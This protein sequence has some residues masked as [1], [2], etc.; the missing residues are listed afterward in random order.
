MADQPQTA[1]TGS[2]TTPHFSIEKL[3]LKDVSFESP[4]SPETFTIEGN[5]DISLQLNTETQTVGDDFYEVVLVV[6]AMAKV[7][8]KTAF[9]VELKQAGIFAVR[10]IPEADMA[11][12]LGIECPNILFSYAREAI[13][14]LTTKGG[15]QPLVLQPINF[16]AMFA[17][18]QAK[19][20]GE[21]EGVTLN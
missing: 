4:N 2:D 11:P 3:Y 17:E 6:T 16:A 10:N 7:N 9:L 15:F 5:P 8:D 1:D 19:K 18:A 12:L 13:S 20:Q 14:D 21:Q